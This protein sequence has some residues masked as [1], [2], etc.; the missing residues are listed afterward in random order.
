[1]GGIGF[2]G[3]YLGKTNNLKLKTQNNI[4]KIDNN[5]QSTKKSVIS[6]TPS[7]SSSGVVVSSGEKYFSIVNGKSDMVQKENLRLTTNR[8][9]NSLFKIIV[10]DK[11]L[12][13]Q[14]N[15]NLK[16]IPINYILKEEGNLVEEIDQI[17]YSINGKEAIIRISTFDKTK[18]GPDIGGGPAP[19]KIDEYRFSYSNNSLQSSIL[20]NSAYEI[21]GVGNKPVPAI[22]GPSTVFEAWN[23]DNDFLYAIDARYGEG[24][25][26]ALNAYYIVDTKG[27]KIINSIKPESNRDISIEEPFLFPSQHKL[28]TVKNDYQEKLTYIK[29]YNMDKPQEPEIQIQV[30]LKVSPETSNNMSLSIRPIM[31]SS[32]GK[33]ILVASSESYPYLYRNLLVNLSTKEIEEINRSSSMDGNPQLTPDDQGIVFIEPKNVHQENTGVETVVSPRTLIYVDRQSKESKILY[34]SK[35]DFSFIGFTK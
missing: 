25:D 17:L 2:G 29:I 21:L 15:S 6:T 23:S 10:K 14:D 34:T 18:P 35:E 33:T 31:F 8:L 26:G 19:E 30:D 11:N 22:E 4:T 5:S 7:V 9:E 12:Y 32:D 3:W 16:E 1:M 20:F 27:K 24:G 28:I 13:A